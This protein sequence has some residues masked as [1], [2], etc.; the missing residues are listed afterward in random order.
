MQSVEAWVQRCIQ[1]LHHESRAG[2]HM[3][4][5]LPVKVL[6]CL[7]CQ[8]LSLSRALSIGRQQD[9]DASICYIHIVQSRFLSYSYL[10]YL[11]P[12]ESHALDANTSHPLPPCS[13]SPSSSLS[14]S[15]HTPRHTILQV[16]T[17]RMAPFPTPSPHP[18]WGKALLSPPAQF[19]TPCPI[20]CRFLPS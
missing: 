5:W 4:Q 17:W 18:Q 6:P 19:R 8:Y 13:T 12:S 10:R 9:I 3:Q 11:F 2:E 7:P 15:G 14:N 20:T 1:P 16:S